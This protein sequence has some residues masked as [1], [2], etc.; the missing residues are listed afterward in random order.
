MTTT[1]E[2]QLNRT[3][4]QAEGNPYWRRA[5]LVLGICFLM[6]Q[7]DTGA[8]MVA[9]PEMARE[10]GEAPARMGLVI[11]SYMLTL[12]VFIPISGWVADR[13]GAKRVFLCAV[14]AYMA[15]SLCSA[16]AGTLGQLIAARMLQGVATSMMAPV[17]RLMLLRSVSRADIVRGITLMSTPAM[18]GPV[19]G[20][21]IGGLAVSFGSWR[22]IFLMNL[23]ISLFLLVAAA[24][25]LHPQPPQKVGRLDLLGFLL[26][27]LALLGAQAAAENLGGAFLPAWLGWSA[28][29]VAVAAGA[30]YFAHTRR[31][32]RPVLRLG[33]FRYRS[34]RIGVIAGG[35]GRIGLTGIVFLLQLQLQ[36]GFGLA[37]H[38]AGGL[39]FI[40]G[41]GSLLAKLFTARIFAWLGFRRALILNSLIAGALTA[42]LALL[43]PATPQVIILMLLLIIGSVRS[44]HYNGSNALSY[45][46]LP[47]RRQ[48][49]GVTLG[50]VLQQLTMALGVTLSAIL[51]AWIGDDGGYATGFIVLGLFPAAAALGFL[52][53]T[54]T[55]GLEASGRSKS[56]RS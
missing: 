39:V 1:T 41:L 51:V 53:L 19:V 7:L 5:A 45:A 21:L 15:G 14:C 29:G 48:T 9:I 6:E 2:S 34:F 38:I 20:P 24:R 16:A 3:K 32:T 37:P 56:E 33:L 49:E 43:T 22:W 54:P 10:F 36:V 12:A 44:W 27:G 18:I 30:A 28:A 42:S 25:V 23:P 40:L 4:P 31:V 26:C 47:K 13:Y 35:L 11:T 46:E 52:R 55:D 17:G 8:V 50:S